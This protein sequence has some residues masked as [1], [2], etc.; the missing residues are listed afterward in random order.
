M[1]TNSIINEQRIF[2][3]NEGAGCVFAALAARNPAKYGWGHEIINDVSSKNIDLIIDS[4]K[5]KKD[6]STLSLIFP[7][8]RTLFD[9]C[10]FIS[11]LEKCNNIIVEKENYLGHECF[12]FRV[13]CQNKLSWVTGFGPFSFFP[14][15]R[16]SP[17]TEI[18]FRIK[19]KPHYDFE[20]K[21]CDEDILHLAHMEMK[22]MGA[23]HF[24]KVWSS[25]LTKTEKLLGHKP[26]FISAAKT[27]FSIPMLQVEYNAA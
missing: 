15:T 16:T 26:D 2:Y 10:N 18:S 3:K 27:T 23:N 6:I 14:A 4:F 21:K 7:K 17:H 24:K 9:L 1:N 11:T 22:G 5:E 8:V 12:G 25:S 13:K 20:M 19:P